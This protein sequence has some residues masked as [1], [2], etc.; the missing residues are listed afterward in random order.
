[1]YSLDFDLDASQQEM[2]VS[3]LFL[4]GAV[5][6]AVGG[7]LCDK[8]GRKK[9]IIITDAMFLFGAMGLYIAQTFP[10]ILIGRFIVGFAVALSGIADV[11]Y[12]HEISPVDW[13]G[14][15]VSVNEACISLGFLVS[16]VAGYGIT[17]WVEHDGW[18]YMF[19]A[20]GFISLLQLVGMRFMPESPVWLQEKGRTEEARIVFDLIGYDDG[21]DSTNS[22]DEYPSCELEERKKRVETIEDYG[23]EQPACNRRQKSPSSQ[24]LNSSNNPSESTSPMQELDYSSMNTD[25]TGGGNNMNSSSPQNEFLASYRQ[26]IIAA[27]LSIMQQFCGHPNVLN[28]APEIFAQVGVASLFS[29]VLLGVLKFS[30]TCFVIWKIEHF[31]RKLLLLL[32][33]SIISMSLLSLV[34]AFSSQDEEGNMPKFSQVLAVTGVFGV[35]GGY[36]CSFG[37]LTW[38]LVSELFHS[39]VRGRAL[40]A[41]TIITYLAGAIVSY[42]FLSVQASSGTWV[43]FAIYYILTVLSIFFVVV[44]IPDT[45][46]KDPMSI[47]DELVELWFWRRMKRKSEKKKKFQP[48]ENHEVV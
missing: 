8:A 18:R 29:T 46:G 32:G 25:E 48:C 13:R 10:E 1:M 2:I 15:I 23:L 17:Q 39:S 36:A 22:N 16:Y 41:S 26:M 40:G 9:A 33:M 12:L 27:F 5:G 6:A 7:T 31:G 11:A 3:F 44:A 24:Y 4:G 38:L 30:I 34:I 37:P 45:A 20:G 35:A 19:G 43:P 14:S 28:Y 47:Q 42:S 21:N